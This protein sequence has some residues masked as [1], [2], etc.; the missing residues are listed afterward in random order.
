MLKVFKT[1][2]IIT[3]TYFTTI[4][5]KPKVTIFFLRQCFSDML[6]N[7]NKLKLQD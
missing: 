5:T 1:S 6:K 7:M 4:K 3:N 2:V